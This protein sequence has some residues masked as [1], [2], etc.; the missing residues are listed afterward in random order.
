MTAREE[1]LPLTTAV[2]I[3]TGRRVHLS[4]ALRWAQRGCRGVRLQTWVL[5][6][7]RLTTQA[8]VREFIA[9]RTDAARQPVSPLQR[10]TFSKRSNDIKHA[11]SELD[12]TLE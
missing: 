9:A 1:M 2:E 10:R 8:A 4:T 12:R 7:R 6:G 11:E 3:V 5:G